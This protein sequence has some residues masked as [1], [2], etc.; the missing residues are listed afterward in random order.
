MNK[1]LLYFLIYVNQP[2]IIKWV[3]QGWGRWVH[4]RRVSYVPPGRWTGHI[5]LWNSTGIPGIPASRHPWHTQFITQ[6]VPFALQSPICAYK[7]GSLLYWTDGISVDCAL[8]VLFYGFR[9]SRG[10]TKEPL[11]DHLMLSVYLSRPFFSESVK[12]THS[13][14]VQ[15]EMSLGK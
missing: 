3:E 8:F 10:K 14:L 12:S 5:C 13:R 2:L 9:T 11:K 4:S 7:A 6:A 1:N 15:N